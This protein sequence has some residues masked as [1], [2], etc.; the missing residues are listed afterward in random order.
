M[1]K[2]YH[3]VFS[4][5]LMILLTL[6]ILS[7]TILGQ[8]VI[9]LTI[10]PPK[11]WSG[12][13][14]YKEI[15]I[16]YF[17]GKMA[18]KGI[19]VKVKIVDYPA[20]DPPFIERTILDLKAGTAPDII[21]V[22]S[23]YVGQWAEAGYLYPLTDFV[24]EWP[25]WEKYFEPLKRA[26]IWKGDVYAVLIET[27]IRPVYYR[28]DIFKAAGLPVPW[29]PKSWDDILE[30]A[31]TIKAK[32]EEIKAKLGIDELYPIAFKMGK[33]IEEATPM[34]GFYMLL[35]GT[36]DWIFDEKA[37]KW[38]AKSGG[39]LDSFKFLE[40]I[41]K[42]GLT[43]PTD[44]WFAPDPIDLVHRLLAEGKL[45]IF[46]TWQGVWYD[47][48]N[49]AHK[50]YVPNRDEVVGYTAMPGRRKFL[51]KEY[52]TDPEKVTVSGGWTLAISHNSK[53]PDLAWE[54]IRSVLGTEL[55]VVRM[56]VFPG[57]LPPG[58][59]VSEDPLYKARTDP[60]TLWAVE[61]VKYTIFRPSRAEYP[62]VSSAVQEATE[63]ILAGKSAE[64]VMD[65][66]A[67]K[68]KEIAP[69]A[70]IEKP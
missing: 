9:E 55:S 16:P 19:L 46:P 28:K 15:W 36:G 23:F 40:I 8:E 31:R 61:L 54:F 14:F 57:G 68:I 6:T 66:Y 37:G 59:H 11:W 38:V 43:V 34:Q 42:E 49:P 63:L 21:F 30:A 47:M 69:E 24:K 58:T 1:F 35:A 48:G 17:E 18:E 64:E 5:S 3:I 53:H 56:I 4:V 45:A 39:L 70:W 20:P 41:H 26:V 27:D 32:A 22:D 12:F 44:L 13:R 10:A 51:G 62:Y 7:P 67:E 29:E 65:W 52:P 50:W 25:E 33:K 60:Y 2:R